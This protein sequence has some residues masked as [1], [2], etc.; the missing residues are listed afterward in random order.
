MA[1]N[2]RHIDAS[3]QQVFEVLA[4]GW[5]YS[6]WVVGTSHMRAV[7]PHWPEVG[8]KLFHAAGAWPMAVRDQ[9]EVE[10]MERDRRLVLLASG[11]WMGQ[12]RIVLELEPSGDGCDVSIG[13]TPVSGPGSLVPKP[14]SDAVIKGR[15]V[16]SLNRLAALAERRSQ[17]SE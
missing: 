6:N 12:A 13:E 5:L 17:P 7:E 14:L 1:V 10:E 16:E 15:N 8:S 11:K 3:P 9:T 2:R 4:D